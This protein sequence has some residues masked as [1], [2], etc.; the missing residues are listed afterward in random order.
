LALA[1]FPKNRPEIEKEALHIGKKQRQ[2]APESDKKLSPASARKLQMG[3]GDSFYGGTQPPPASK[4]I[5]RM[6]G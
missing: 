1:V 4:S 6:K 3:A 5:A 2:L